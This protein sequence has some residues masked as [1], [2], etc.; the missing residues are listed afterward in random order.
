MP[1]KTI[2]WLLNPV[3]AHCSVDDPLC[4]SRKLDVLLQHKLQQGHAVTAKRWEVSEHVAHL[5]IHRQVGYCWRGTVATSR[6]I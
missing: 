5:R 3:N 2:A 6:A 4:D 1:G